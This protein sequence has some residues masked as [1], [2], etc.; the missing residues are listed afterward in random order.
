[1]DA[2]VEH[3]VNGCDVAGHEEWN[4]VV[5]PQAA[6]AVYNALGARQIL[7][8]QTMKTYKWLPLS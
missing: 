7:G 4:P 8:Q 1:M 2:R 5:V 6:Q 3:L